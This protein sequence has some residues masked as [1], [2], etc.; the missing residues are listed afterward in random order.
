[1]SRR[2]WDKGAAL[3]PQQQDAVEARIARMRQRI[4]SGEGVGWY[5]RGE[6]LFAGLHQDDADEYGNRYTR[7]AGTEINSS[8]QLLAAERAV[9]GGRPFLPTGFPQGVTNDAGSS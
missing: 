7:S 4:E 3:T 2:R 9:W 8:K 6:L 1:M 5:D